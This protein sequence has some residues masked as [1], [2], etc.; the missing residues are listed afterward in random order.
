MKETLL[1]RGAGAPETQES[2]E[3]WVHD[4]VL[5]LPS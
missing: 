5:T 1:P 2:L 3:I 4:F